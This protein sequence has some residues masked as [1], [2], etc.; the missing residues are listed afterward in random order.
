MCGAETISPL[1]QGASVNQN[2]FT[3]RVNSLTANNPQFAKNMELFLAEEERKQEEQFQQ[4]TKET[5]AKLINEST[6]LG[7]FIAN[8]TFAGNTEIRTAL[9][10]IDLNKLASLII[11]KEKNRLSKS[12]EPL[13]ARILA[14]MTAP[15]AKGRQFTLTKLRQ[16][17]PLTEKDVKG[18]RSSN[19]N[20]MIYN[21]F[22]K[23]LY[24]LEIN[25]AIKAV[26]AK[27]PKN[28]CRIAYVLA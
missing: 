3:M 5:L 17:V 9:R 7:S 27:D 24:T 4:E 18:R 23:A 16:L 20:Q 1:L 28:N 6:D 8:F 25:K 26:E 11:Q 15:N 10:K 21:I 22:Y 2:S 14:V 13:T 19:I 12:E